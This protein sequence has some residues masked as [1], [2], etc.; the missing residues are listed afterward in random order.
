MWITCSPPAWLGGLWGGLVCVMNGQACVWVDVGRQC[1]KGGAHEAPCGWR[2]RVH[3]LVG[4]RKIAR[5]IRRFI[6]AEW[7]RELPVRFVARLDLRGRRCFVQCQPGLRAGGNL[8]SDAG[9]N[10]LKN[11]QIF[12]NPYG[13][14]VARYQIRKNLWIT[15]LALALPGGFGGGFVGAMGW[16]GVRLVGTVLSTCGAGGAKRCGAAGIGKAF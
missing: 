3:L 10:R 2:R 7:A 12:Q 1:V 15:D 9:L 14:C 5:R 16:A 11:H 8:R 13:C 4:M 6:R